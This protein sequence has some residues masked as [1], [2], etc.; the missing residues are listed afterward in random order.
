MFIGFTRSKNLFLCDYNKQQR[1]NHVNK[2]C[3]LYRKLHEKLFFTFSLFD[4]T[5]LDLAFKSNIYYISTTTDE[6]QKLQT[7]KNAHYNRLI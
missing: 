2:R 4:I 3:F 1:S 5:T 6:K 7:W